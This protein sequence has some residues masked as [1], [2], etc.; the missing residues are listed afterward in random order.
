MFLVMFVAQIA[1]IWL[2]SLGGK[3]KDKIFETF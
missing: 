1:I 2:L 3:T